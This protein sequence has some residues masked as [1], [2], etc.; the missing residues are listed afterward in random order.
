MTVLRGEAAPTS[1]TLL[2]GVA[3]FAEPLELAR[4]EIRILRIGRLRDQ[5]RQPAGRLRKR[6][7]QASGAESRLVGAA[8]HATTCE[9]SLNCDCRN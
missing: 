5:D 7:T 9:S 1:F 4:R 2:Q 6:L 8:S 3:E